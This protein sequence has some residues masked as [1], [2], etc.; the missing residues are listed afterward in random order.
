VAPGS[1][2]AVNGG[3]RLTV[4]AGQTLSLPPGSI[5]SSDG[6]CS[7]P[8]QVVVNGTLAVNAATL[9]WVVLS[10]SGRVTQEGTSTWDL[11]GTA[12]SPG[13]AI[14][15]SGVINGDLP[16]G[17]STLTPAGVLRV[18]GDYLAGAPGTL[19]VDAGR[20][21]VDGNAELAGTLKSAVGQVARNK[22]LDVVSAPS[23]QGAFSCAITPS[24]VPIY[25]KKKVSLLG[26][27]GA[28]PDCLVAAPGKALKAKFTG[29]RM[30]KL[31]PTKGATRVM[32]KVTLKGAAADTKLTLRAGSSATVKVAKGTSVTAYV[33]L[34][35][36]KGA[37]A[38]KLTASIARLTSVT[39]TQIGFY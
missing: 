6:C 34:K 5:L 35:L 27:P 4:P 3:T 37:K 33:V 29:T 19:V 24:A 28:P 26:V 1:T 10:G 23:V 38:K 12:F 18:T 30:G 25:S 9:Q 22:T 16:S 36:A 14:S 13:A 32:L 8:G 17:A 20:L 21:Q 31:K 11:A 15:A 39:V 7:N 2:L